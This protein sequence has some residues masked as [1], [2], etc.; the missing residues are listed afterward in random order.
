MLKK[1]EIKILIVDDEETIGLSIKEYFD[2]EADK[3]FSFSTK[4]VSNAQQAFKAY[5]EENFNIVVLDVRLGDESGISLLKKMKEIKSEPEILLLTGFGNKDIAIEALK[6]GAYDFLGKPFELSSL[7]SIII[8]AYEKHK[9]KIGKGLSEQKNKEIGKIAYQGELVFLGESFK[10][11]QIVSLISDISDTDCNVLIQG[12]SGT[13]KDLVARLIHKSSLRVNEVFFPIN[14][15]AIPE[16]LLESELFGYEK[17][18]FTGANSRKLGLFEIAEKGTLFLDEIGDLPF[19]FQV[20]LLRVLESGEFMRIGGDRIITTDARV[21]CATNKD[22]KKEVE[23]NLFRQDL[24]YRLNVISI[25]LPTLKERKEDLP[26]LINYFIKK[27]CKEINKGVCGISKEAMEL[28]IH[29]D[30][31]G[32][33]RELQNLID[34]MIIL[35]HG[36]VITPEVVA[37]NLSELDIHSEPISSNLPEDVVPLL[38]DGEEI[39]LEELEKRYITY[40]LKRCDYKK[41]LAASILQISERTLYRKIKEYALYQENAMKSL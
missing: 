12:E 16:N 24:Y 5:E 34:K 31:P 13:G 4:F 7:K 29:Y 37:S 36:R 39:T 27:R 1:E 2:I 10:M 21:I 30:W 35:T 22:L 17:G 19:S 3:N 11:K 41:S 32:N 14:C 8:K 23:K 26:L 38:K 18:A 15:G 20:K 6:A 25:Y 28:L 40:I 33:V 9:I